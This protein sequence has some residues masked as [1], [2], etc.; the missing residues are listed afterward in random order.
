MIIRGWSR[1]GRKVSACVFIPLAAV[2]TVLAALYAPE[3]LPVMFGFCG[4]SLLLLTPLWRV[5]YPVFLVAD[6]V[7][8]MRAGDASGIATGSAALLLGV[9]IT[10]EV[11]KE[12]RSERP[13]R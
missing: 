13:I 7:L 3:N 11:Y 1:K 2:F 10:A 4:L 5:F 12:Y 9:F 8:L 6:G